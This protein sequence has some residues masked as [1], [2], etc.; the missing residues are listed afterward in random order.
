MKVISSMLLIGVSALALAGSAQA[1]DSGAAEAGHEAAAEAIIVTGSRIVS[2]GGQSPQ[3]LT[4]VSAEELLK[5]SP[6]NIIDALNTVPEFAASRSQT[7]N[8]ST[9]L[10]SGG[11]SAAAN[12][13]NLR[14]LGAIRTLVL[15]DNQRLPSGTAIGTV[16]AD[17]IPEMLIK[18]VETVTGGVSAVYGSDAVSGV[19]NFVTDR[20]FK[21]IK[22]VA[23]VGQS[24]HGDDTSYKFGIAAGAELFDGR[25]HIEFSASRYH[26][27][28]IVDRNLQRP[29]WENI[30]VYGSAN[31]TATCNTAANPCTSLY[32]NRRNAA[33]TYAG[34]VNSTLTAGIQSGRTFSAD[35]TSLV[36]FNNGTVMPQNYQSGGDGYLNNNASLKSPLTNN[37]QYGRFDYEV[38]DAVHF[39]AQAVFNEKTNFQNLN[40]LNI[41][42]YVLRSDNGFLPA[43]FAGTYLGGAS[44]FK[45]SKAFQSFMP[46]MD[47][48]AFQYSAN[49]GLDGKAG[50]FHWSADL[51]SGGS[52]VI[53]YMNHNL[54]FQHLA[55]ALDATGSKACYA[56]T[57]AATSGAYADCVAFN[58]FGTA[59]FSQAALDYVAPRTQYLNLTNTLKSAALSI[60]GRAF[61]GWAGPIEVALSA[62]WRETSLSFTSEGVGKTIDCTGLR[63]PCNSVNELKNGAQL[64]KNVVANMDRRSQT[65]KEAAFEAKIPLL[66]DL[67]LIQSLEF[68][69]AARYTDYNTTG[70]YTTWKAGLHWEIDDSISLRG[71]IS[72]DIR[73]PTLYELFQPVTRTYPSTSTTYV[74]TGTTL[75]SGNYYQQSSGNPDLT[76]EIGKTKTAGIVF[77][78]KFLRGLSLAVDYYDIAVSKAILTSA[79]FSGS[80]A[81]VQWT[82]YNSGG[83]SPLCALIVGNT[84]TGA[85]QGFISANINANRLNTSGQDIE[86]GYTTRALAGPLDLRL[87]VAHQPHVYINTATS[88]NTSGVY[89]FTTSDGGGAVGNPGTP[90]SA[91]WRINASVTLTPL[92]NLSVNV[93]ERWRSALGYTLTPTTQFYNLKVA[94]VGYTDLGVSYKVPSFGGGG[95]LFLNVTNLLNKAP[96]VYG[97]GDTGWT[98]QDDLVGRYVTVGV[99]GKF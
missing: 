53:N 23:Q 83:T 1:Q 95:E 85:V 10:G 78:P 47:I 44:T 52:H 28:G 90:G 48:K 16:D 34:L 32:Y 75:T 69:G 49:V 2:N 72:R 46:S 92:A 59:S 22:Y 80:D 33:A 81:N 87:F 73:A 39:H 82:C 71:T 63:E 45:L 43:G 11:G 41:A 56:S 30:G 86:L 62:D 7:S 70:H 35:G 21:G 4:V 93:R 3:P 74:P 98:Y 65:V 9:G 77:K 51:N 96:P 31:P 60:S 15:L 18:R 99:R 76:A 97:G 58:P 67:P 24:S 8:T 54:N 64:Y 61:E 25:G 88:V 26:D 6:S 40:T 68:N 19:V 50:R 55:A 66:R 94:S 57:Q 36:A 29:D 14:N 17:I 42:T 5:V 84:Q 27:D 13:L 37:Q 12:Q 91:A 38:S 89:S 79:S 20:D